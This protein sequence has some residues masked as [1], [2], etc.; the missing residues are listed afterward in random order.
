MAYKAPHPQRWTWA[1][2]MPD[3]A[4]I[5][6][7]SPED[8]FDRAAR[9]MSIGTQPPVGVHQAM[10][11]FALH[12]AGHGDRRPLDYFETTAARGVPLA[13]RAFELIHLLA[14]A[15]SIDLIRK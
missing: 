13:E 3:G 12:A 11:R 6:G 14:D 5:V 1:I 10:Y 2:E 15:G 4:R 8:V 7:T 9:L